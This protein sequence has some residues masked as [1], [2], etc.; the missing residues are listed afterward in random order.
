MIGASRTCSSSEGGLQLSKCS[1]SVAQEKETRVKQAKDHHAPAPLRVPFIIT[2]SPCVP[3]QSASHSES[4]ALLYP[5]GTQAGV[6]VRSASQRLSQTT[7]PPVPGEQQRSPPWPEQPQQQHHK[8]LFPESS[9]GK[10]GLALTLIMSWCTAQKVFASEGFSPQNP[11]K[12]IGSTLCTQ[13]S[14]INTTLFC[15][16]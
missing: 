16:I 8:K 5:S 11:S 13:M 15:N 2:N 7:L 4:R 6:Q 3:L 9:L 10:A 12:Y 14:Y 1:I